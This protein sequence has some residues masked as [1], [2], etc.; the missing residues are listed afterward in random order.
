MCRIHPNNHM[1]TH[2][3]NK[4]KYNMCFTH[5][6]TPCLDRWSSLAEIKALGSGLYPTASLFNHNCNPNI[7]RWVTSLVGTHRYHRV[8]IIYRVP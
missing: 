7:M 6:Q 3:Q 4:H 1:F 5:A 2:A 8:I